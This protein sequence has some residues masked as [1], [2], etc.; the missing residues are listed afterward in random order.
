M[1][2]LTHYAITPLVIA[3]RIHGGLICAALGVVSVVVDKYRRDAT[4]DQ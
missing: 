1:M 2:T 4:E 3:A